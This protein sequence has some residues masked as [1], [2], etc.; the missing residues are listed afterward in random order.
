MGDGA[1]RRAC[2]TR[3]GARRPLARRRPPA[4]A[5]RSPRWHAMGWSVRAD[6]GVFPPNPTFG[7]LNV[8]VNTFDNTWTWHTIIRSIRPVTACC[9]SPPSL[10]GVK[11]LLVCPKHSHTVCESEHGGRRPEFMAIRLH[12]QHRTAQLVH[13][14]LRSCSP[15]AA[16]PLDRQQ[17]FLRVLFVFDWRCFL[18]LL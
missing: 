5:S 1:R 4:P 16:L 10:C 2:D 11:L 17:S 8:T 13:I 6:G 15:S 14:C 3:R 18:A 7:A 12:T 9:G